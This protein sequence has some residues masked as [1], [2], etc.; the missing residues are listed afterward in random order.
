MLLFYSL[1]P[2]DYKL[3]IYAFEKAF[4]PG[5]TF[6]TAFTKIDFPVA[7]SGTCQACKMNCLEKIVV[8][9]FCKRLNLR[10]LTL[11]P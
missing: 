6:E 2:I 11:S 4:F 10:C 5:F 9:N 8:N 7:Y 1:I 3:S